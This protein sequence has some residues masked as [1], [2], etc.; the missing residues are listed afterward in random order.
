[1]NNYVARTF[2][3]DFMYLDILFCAIWMLVLFRQRQTIAL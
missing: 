1:M 3:M 2:D